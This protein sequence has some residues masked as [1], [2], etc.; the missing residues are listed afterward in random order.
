MNNELDPATVFSFRVN[1]QVLSETQRAKYFTKLGGNIYVT[2]AYEKILYEKIC[3]LTCRNLCPNPN[4]NPSL[5]SVF[6]LATK[7]N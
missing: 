2:N 1:L 5:Q 4:F 7:S 6:L 3:N